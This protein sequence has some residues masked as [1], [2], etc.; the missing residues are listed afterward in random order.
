MRALQKE[1]E[2]GWPSTCIRHCRTQEACPAEGNQGSNTA[3]FIHIC[4]PRLLPWSPADSTVVPLRAQPCTDGLQRFLGWWHGTEWRRNRQQMSSSHKPRFIRNK[5]KPAIIYRLCRIRSSEIRG[6]PPACH[7]LL[8]QHW[9][10]W[11]RAKRDAFG[12]S[13]SDSCFMASRAA[14]KEEKHRKHFYPNNK[15]FSGFCNNPKFKLL[16]GR[17]Q[18]FHWCYCSA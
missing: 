13:P 18:W 12:A 2:L 5:A 8:A 6:I 10:H 14:A 17:C 3:K 4:S 16:G 9:G 1:L 7:D 11:P 15:T